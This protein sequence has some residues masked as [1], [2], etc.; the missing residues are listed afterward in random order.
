M[1]NAKKLA[2]R[3]TSFISKRYNFYGNMMKFRK[4]QN[5]SKELT[6]AKIEVRN[7]DVNG[8]LRRLRKVLER[9]NRQKELSK[10]EY[11]EKGSIKRKRAKGQAKKR[12]NRSIDKQ[13]SSGTYV[14][15][16]PTGVKHLKS[17]RSKR[18]MVELDERIN[19]FKKR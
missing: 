13:I 18:K 3:Y 6:G 19:S 1:C 12:H 10:R 11:H 7:D 16:K 5:Q 2:A 4:P 8:A 15:Y 17:K 9:D 14:P